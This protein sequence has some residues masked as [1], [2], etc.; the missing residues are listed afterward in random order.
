MTEKRNTYPIILVPGLF[1]YGD[2]GLGK[3]LPYFGKAAQYIKE[4][5][6]DCYTADFTPLAGV[7]DR[8]CELYAQIVGGTVDY[9]EAHAK[10]YGTER[11][12]STYPGFVKNLN[13]DNKVTL[14]AYGFGAPVARLLAFLL[15]NGSKKEQATEGNISP[16]FQGGNG[17]SIHAVVTL[18]GNNDGTTFFQALDS[19]V[20][21]TK[22]ATL[23]IWGATSVL[24]AL[25]GKK[26]N[27]YGNLD[28]FDMGEQLDKYVGA[29]RD[30]LFFDCSLEG[31][32]QL[33]KL[34][35]PN[36]NAYYIAFTGEVTKDVMDLLP[37]KKA[38]KHG[39]P[40]TTKQKDLLNVEL[41]VP[42]MDAG[43]LAPTALL[44][45]TFKNYLPNAPIVTPVYHGNDGLIPTNCALAPSTEDY[46]SFRYVEACKPGVWYQMP[47][48]AKNHLNYIG[49]F[50][51]KD[52]YKAMVADI[53]D[54]VCN[55]D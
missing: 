49:L 40:F 27:P 30:N 17:A 55:L 19:F 14:V 33:N 7:W 37:K 6:L 35:K 53:V 10:K 13:E 44:L 51:K 28:L 18:A 41:S 12:G 45:G 34:M 29:E 8:A 2:T 52:E 32:A 26:A 15:E 50:A 54:I 5:G 39:N 9:G 24:A 3:V 1:G 36:K 23:G 47:I 4:E 20:P 42:T 43:V 46:T 25:T 22:F 38:K 11:F 21:F 16:L 31:M 48:E